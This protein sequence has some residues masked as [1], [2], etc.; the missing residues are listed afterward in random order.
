[1]QISWFEQ[2]WSVGMFWDVND[3]REFNPVRPG[4]GVVW[5]SFGRW[6]GLVE[7]IQ[8]AQWQ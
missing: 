3:V 5:Y 4:V 7:W 2:F 6:N 8:I 1:M